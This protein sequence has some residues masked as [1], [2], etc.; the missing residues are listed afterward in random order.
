MSNLYQHFWFARLFNV[1]CN[2]FFVES[3][4]HLTL[5]QPNNEVSPIAV[6]SVFIQN[7]IKLSAMIA[8][9]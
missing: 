8:Y 3:H 1:Y 5:I 6:A 4:S 7:Q 2:V 9:D